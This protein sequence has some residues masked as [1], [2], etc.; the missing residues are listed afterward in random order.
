MHKLTSKDKEGRILVD[1]VYKICNIPGNLG[2]EF[3]TESVLH[4]I[5]QSLIIRQTFHS[6]NSRVQLAKQLTNNHIHLQKY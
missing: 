1:G 5:L 3:I 2:S 6:N 4:I